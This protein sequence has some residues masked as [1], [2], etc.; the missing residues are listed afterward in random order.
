MKI[1][2]LTQTGFDDYCQQ[3]VVAAETSEEAR[4]LS[5]KKWRGSPDKPIAT[6]LGTA[7]NPT[8]K[9]IIN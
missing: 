2:L 3:A 7:H 5:K 6:E 1:F 8:F 4:K 9:G